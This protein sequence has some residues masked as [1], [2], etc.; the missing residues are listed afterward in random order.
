MK[1]KIFSVVMLGVLAVLSVVNDPSAYADVH[2]G[3][4]ADE[5]IEVIMPTESE[6]AYVAYVPDVESGQFSDSY[7][8]AE[9]IVDAGNDIYQLDSGEGDLQE[10]EDVIIE[11]NIPFRASSMWGY[12]TDEQ[13]EDIKPENDSW[14]RQM[15][16]APEDMVTADVGMEA[17]GTVKIAVMDSGIDLISDVPVAG[18]V[19]LV[20]DEQDVTYYMEDMTGHGTAVASV[21]A[22]I[23]P[24]AEIYSVRVLDQNNETD[25]GRL[26]RGIYWCMDNDMDIINM[27]FGTLERSEILE[28]VLEEAEEKGILVVAAAGN[29]GE[30]G[31]D[32]PAAYDSTLAVGGVDHEGEVTDISAVG[33]EVDVVAPGEDIPVESMFGMHTLAGGTSLAAPHVAAEAAILMQKDSSKPKDFIEGLIKDSANPVGDSEE[34]GD[35][36]IDIA[37]AMEEYDNYEDA[38]EKGDPDSHLIEENDAEIETFTEEEISFQGSWGGLNL[39]ENEGHKFAA[40]DAVDKWNA[41]GKYEQISPDALFVI[42]KGAVYPDS[43]KTEVK[44]EKVFKLYWHGIYFTTTHNREINYIAC[45]RFITKIAAFSGDTSNFKKGVYGL[46]KEDYESMKSM[47]SKTGI[48]NKKLEGGWFTWKK[49]MGKDPDDDSRWLYAGDSEWLATLRRCFLYGMAI[50][51]A[52]DVFAHSAFY[53]DASNAFVPI[54]HLS[55]KEIAKYKE[56]KNLANVHMQIIHN[57]F[58]SAMKMP[59]WLR[60][61]R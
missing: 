9:L 50:H 7:D 13:Y 42:K 56:F 61:G 27:S 39:D 36:L 59:K 3:Q 41:T 24:Q 5:T 6:A 16:N 33:E 8:D 58:T 4:E 2:E 19:N 43:C 30:D 40:G 53:K 55:E 10:S 25:L 51:Q 12:V 46:P 22:G 44:K 14:N 1:K 57:L 34:Y 47:V 28:K 35:G 60:S 29:Q 17:A 49:A 26:V 20:E 48:G 31:V 45:Y 32:Y 18:R 21:I 38:C 37:Y 54:K 23:S 52:T 15:V 11:E